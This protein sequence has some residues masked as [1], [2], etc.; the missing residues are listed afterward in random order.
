MVPLVSKSMS[1]WSSS[2][3][4]CTLLEERF[5]VGTTLIEEAPPET[6]DDSNLLT[7]AI[8]ENTSFL[9]LSNDHL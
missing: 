4:S 2:K 5:P 3:A 8:K 1:A 7:L 6:E 9:S